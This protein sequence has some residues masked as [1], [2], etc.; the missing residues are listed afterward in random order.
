MNSKI[1]IIMPVLNEANSLG[2]TLGQLHLSD[3]EELIV[4]DGGSSDETV[5]TAREYTDNVYS[6][7]TGRASVMNYGAQK[8]EG[9]ILLFLHADC[10]LPDDGFK[11]IRETLSNNKVSAGAFSLRIDHP[12]FKFRIIEFGS[13]LRSHV[14]STVY[15]DQGIFLK[16]ET[17]AL[18]G[19]YNDI[20]LMEDI[21]ISRK[22]LKKGKLFLINNPMKVSPRRWLKE[23]ALYST[24]RDWSLAFSYTFLKASPEHLIRHYKDIR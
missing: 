24:L 14:C 16:K 2:R 13:N 4:V 8:A 5:L 3:Y 11:M 23:G 22:L 18:I 19:G 15:G 7:K 21:D 1:S 20:P 9:A 10:I 17:F 12:S 6:T